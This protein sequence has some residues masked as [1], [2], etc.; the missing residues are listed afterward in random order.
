MRL[1]T[2]FAGTAAI[3]S[4]VLQFRSFFLDG[5]GITEDRL[6][7]AWNVLLIPAALVLGVSLARRA[8]VAAIGLPA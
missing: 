6:V 5:F 1:V 7:L 4:G 2:V 8:P 3:V